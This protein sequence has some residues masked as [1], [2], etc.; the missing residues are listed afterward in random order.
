MAAGACECIGRCFFIL[1]EE[2]IIRRVVRSLRLGEYVAPWVN[3]NCFK[4]HACFVN[5]CWR[6]L[7]G[8]SALSPG[9]RP[10]F[11]GLG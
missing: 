1:P 6:A 7:K 4:N 2:R 3:Q 9:Q 5:Q 8:Q 11:H 10:G